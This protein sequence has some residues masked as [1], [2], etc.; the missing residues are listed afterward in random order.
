M[1]ANCYLYLTPDTEVVDSNIEANATEQP[2]KC[3]DHNLDSQARMDSAH[4]LH[5]P[6]SLATAVFALGDSSNKQYPIYAPPSIPNADNRTT[7][8]T[9]VFDMNTA[10]MTLLGNNPR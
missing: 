6:T 9:V 10:V 1:G 5:S 2:W 4:G 8:N 3:I 7:L